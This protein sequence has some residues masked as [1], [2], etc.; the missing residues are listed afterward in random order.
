MLGGI[1]VRTIENLHR[2][3]QIEPLR[4]PVKRGFV[5][6]ILLTTILEL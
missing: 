4:R 2:D 1:W 6:S 3:E 5:D